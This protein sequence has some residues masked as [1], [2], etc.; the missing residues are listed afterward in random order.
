MKNH[1]F[2]ISISILLL[3][4]CGKKL[5]GTVQ[6]D[7]IGE[8]KPHDYAPV[9]VVSEEILKKYLERKF[10]EDRTED[11]QKLEQSLPLRIKHLENTKELNNKLQSLMIAGIFSSGVYDSSWQ[12]RE[13][14]LSDRDRLSNAMNANVKTI[15]NLNSSIEK[16]TAE[17]DSIKLDIENIKSGRSGRH[18]YSDQI[19]NNVYKTDAN[20]KFEIS[21]NNNGSQYLVVRGIGKFWCRKIDVKQDSIFLTDSDTVDVSD[22]IESCPNI[23][24]LHPSHK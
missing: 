4:G 17:I 12:E 2:L 8:R 6:S 21:Y 7:T 22:S 23:K 18:F 19:G 5:N 14:F 10:K 24:S 15:N 3:C 9:E 16:L 11:I 20:G 1:F 13:R